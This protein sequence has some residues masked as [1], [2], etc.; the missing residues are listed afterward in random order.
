MITTF[1]NSSDKEQLGTKNWWR[2]SQLD[3]LSCYHV[4]ARFKNTHKLEVFLFCRY[5]E[6]ILL[7]RENNVS[8]YKKIQSNMVN[9]RITK[10][11]V[12]NFREN[13]NL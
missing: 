7:T 10:E 6:H 5:S 2:I 1:I 8:S 13:L 9:F 12:S 4:P 3:I 11:Q